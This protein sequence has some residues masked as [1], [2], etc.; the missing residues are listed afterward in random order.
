ML[1]AA[2]PD[3]IGGEPADL[4]PPPAKQAAPLSPV[5]DRAVA[6]SILAKA[7]VDRAERGGSL[8]SRLG[9]NGRA[10]SEFMAFCG[11]SE[12]D[13][14]RDAAAAAEAEPEEQA[15]VRE[16]LL[17]HCADDA[18]LATALAA[19]VARRAMEA[20]HLWEDLGLND[21]SAL[22]HLMGR[23]F[24]DLASQNTNNMRWK[25]FLYRRLCE[26][27]GVMHCTSPTCSACA[28]VDKCF[29]D[30]SVERSIAVAKQAPR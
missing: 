22:T 28:D 6:F 15:W 8:G 16:L 18:P 27:E 7:F 13:A 10:L 2:Y 29:E 24:P 1:D 12:P 17:R 3:T 14:H 5:F 4:A 30:G 26:E 25:R 19:I 9:L 11:W 20:N 23:H 21:R